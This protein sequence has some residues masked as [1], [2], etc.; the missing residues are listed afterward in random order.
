MKH[1]PTARYK[2]GL[3]YM[4]FSLMNCVYVS[5]GYIKSYTMEYTH[6][7]PVLAGY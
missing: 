2:S 3:K 7:L 4:A 1:L 6:I 5:M